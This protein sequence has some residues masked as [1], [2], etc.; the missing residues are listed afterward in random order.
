MV[1]SIHRLGKLLGI[2]TVAESVS[3]A[4]AAD[5]LREIGVDYGQGNWLGPPRPLAAMIAG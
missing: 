1:E 5:L 4:A 2:E 3:S